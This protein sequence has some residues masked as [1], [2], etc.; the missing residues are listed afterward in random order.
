MGQLQRYLTFWF[1]CGISFIGSGNSVKFMFLCQS[2]VI[3]K[4]YSMVCMLSN[5][6]ERK[7]INRKGILHFCLQCL[8]KAARQNLALRLCLQL[9]KEAFS[10]TNAKTVLTL[11]HMELRV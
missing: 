3:S 7:G 11:C 6:H 10:V 1:T 9:H 8:F 5:F 4:T 2:P